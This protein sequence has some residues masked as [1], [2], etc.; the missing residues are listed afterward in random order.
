MKEHKHFKTCEKNGINEKT[1]KEI[2]LE[3]NSWDINFRNKPH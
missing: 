1:Q 3:M 2:K